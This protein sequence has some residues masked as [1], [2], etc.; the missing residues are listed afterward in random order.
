MFNLVSKYLLSLLLIVMAAPVY[1]EKLPYQIDYIKDTP[2]GP[3][4]KLEGEFREGLTEYALHALKLHPDVIGIS[5]SS[6]GGS[7]DEGYKLGKAMSDYNLIMW[8][9]KG[10]AC[11]S[12]CALAFI[13]GWK[14]LVGGILAF[15]SPYLPAYTPE[16][17]LET[18]YKLGEIT[19]VN[20]MHY[21]AANGFRAQLYMTIAQYTDK[22]TFMIFTNTN[23]LHHFLMIEDRT[24]KDY[25]SFKTQPKTV[26]Q[27]DME[28]FKEIVLQKNAELFE[29][30]MG[31]PAD[32]HQTNPKDLLDAKKDKVPSGK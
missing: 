19:G 27:G 20:Q 4:L 24:Y 12:A 5:M 6:P 32:K 23:D 30:L 2:I 14:Y 16:M 25:L 22:E 10:K 13:G 11:V 18:I 31:A 1:G 3:L 9:P 15:H 17:K 8:V 26:I 29:E 7:L 28:K 21:F